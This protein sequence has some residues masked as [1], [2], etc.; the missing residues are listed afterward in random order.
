ML[1]QIINSSLSLCAVLTLSEPLKFLK[2]TLL[3]V[4]PLVL[5]C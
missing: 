5:D 4:K 3:V 1:L 2:T